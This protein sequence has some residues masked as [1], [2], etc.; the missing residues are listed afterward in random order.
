MRPE[1]IGIYANDSETL[2]KWYIEKL[3]LQITRTL[4]KEGRSTIYFLES[5]DGVVLEILPTA[6]DIKTRALNTPGFSHIGF[7]VDDFE[8]T[9]AALASKGVSIH[10]ARQTSNGWRIGYFEDPEGNSLEIVYRP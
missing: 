3:G 1:H 2:A 5:Q 7:V 9:V 10:D 8:K 4:E 6:A